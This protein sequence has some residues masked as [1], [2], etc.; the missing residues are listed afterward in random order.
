MGRGLILLVFISGVMNPLWATT[1]VLHRKGPFQLRSGFAA[2]PERKIPTRFEEWKSFLIQNYPE[3]DCALE[4]PQGANLSQ[5]RKKSLKQIQQELL[6]LGFPKTKV[7]LTS[8]SLRHDL[9]QFFCV[10]L[11]KKGFLNRS[12]AREPEKKNLAAPFPV[13]ACS[14][15]IAQEGERIAVEEILN[16]LGGDS[17]IHHM[18]NA[19][20]EIEHC[21][22]LPSDLLNETSRHRFPGEVDK[23][24][25]PH[26][27]DRDRTQEKRRSQGQGADH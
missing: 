19:L 22:S 8:D 10:E 20:S 3:G 1:L 24:T 27:E 23:D 14:R 15:K 17:T 18:K 16:A 21:E 7:L 25:E 13:S 4:V 5:A 9:Y 26:G 2:K 12:P 11:P 6:R